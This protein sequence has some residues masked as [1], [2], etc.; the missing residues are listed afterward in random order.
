MKTKTIEPLAMTSLVAA[1]AD[2]K[3]ADA[4]AA[5]AKKALDSIKS[6]LALEHAD[7]LLKS[8]NGM[9]VIATFNSREVRAI[10]AR[11]DTFHSFKTVVK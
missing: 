4:V 11:T 1:L 5:S 9:E 6:A 2:K 10:D 3:Q 8:S 7:Y